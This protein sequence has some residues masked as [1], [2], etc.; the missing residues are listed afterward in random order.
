MRAARL[1]A[2]EAWVLANAT[3][4]VACVFRGR[5][6]C[7]RSECAS[8]ASARSA[9]RRLRT[10][11][12]VLIYA[13]STAS[14]KPALARSSRADFGPS[15]PLARSRDRAHPRQRIVVPAP[16]AYNAPAKLMRRP[17]GADPPTP[18]SPPA[19]RG[20]GARRSS[21]TTRT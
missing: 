13:R 2:H 4:F 18:P 6:R 5:G 7:E 8:L 10:D 16:T 17:L 12:P 15:R 19:K 1:D 11:R 3:R 9:A 14:A 21:Y 20:T